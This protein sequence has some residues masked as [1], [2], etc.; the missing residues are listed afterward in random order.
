MAKMLVNGKPAD[1]LVLREEISKYEQTRQ[2]M[3][4]KYDNVYISDKQIIEVLAK[5][6][7]QYQD[8]IKQQERIIDNLS[9]LN[10]SVNISVEEDEDILDDDIEEIITTNKMADG[11]IVKTITEYKYKD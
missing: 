4:V 7:K 3:I 5:E 2:R 11:K 9:K 8:R 6:I 10:E 1:D